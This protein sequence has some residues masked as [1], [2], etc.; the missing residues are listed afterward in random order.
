MDA[1]KVKRLIDEALL[2]NESL[3]LVDWS[4]SP[5]N[6]IQVLVDGD[7]GLPIEEVVRISRHIESNLDR[8]QD[9]FALT[10]SSPG[11]DRPL[12]MPRQYQKN[13]G[14]TLKIKTANQEIKGEVIKVT[15]DAVTLQWKQRE[16]KP[17]G[18]G[19]HTVQKEEEVPFEEIE[20][21]TIHIDI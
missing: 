9:D 5:G 18:K 6:Q 8:E 11:L 14:R 21:A 17:V 4:I 16:P 19:K 3:F 20:K 10:V 2:E 13:M 1:S 12:K 7:D 15:D